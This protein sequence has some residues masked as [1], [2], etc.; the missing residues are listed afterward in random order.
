MEDTSAL[1]T[2]AHSS[3][4]T[5]IDLVSNADPGKLTDALR[6]GKADDVSGVLGSSKE[7]LGALLLGMIEELTDAD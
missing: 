6:A 2:P 3:T 7:E 4:D 1:S 5:L